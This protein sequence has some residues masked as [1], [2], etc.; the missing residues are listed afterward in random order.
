MARN[1]FGTGKKRTDIGVRKMNVCKGD[2]VRVIRGAFAGKEGT[3]IRAIPRE[4]RV[5]VEG[6]NQRKRHAR[7][8][9]ANPEGGILTFEAPIHASNV[10]LLDPHSGE[11]TRI[12]R[13]VD[14]DGK[15]ER[16]ATKSGEA[17]IRPR[18]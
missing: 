7:P 8:S 5:V 16:I 9:Q 2:K 4:N 11:P 12:R 15:T 13:R 17:I 3:V 14:S 6:I 18:K 1:V 10:M